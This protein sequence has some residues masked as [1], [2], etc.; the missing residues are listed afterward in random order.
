[1]SSWAHSS[2]FQFFEFS[3]VLFCDVSD[4]KMDM[5]DTVIY[6]MT[7]MNEFDYGSASILYE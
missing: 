1:M 5:M 6:Q 3:T 2:T 7:Y 4:S